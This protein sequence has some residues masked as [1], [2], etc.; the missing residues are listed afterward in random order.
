MILN[1]YKNDIIENKIKCFGTKRTIIKKIRLIKS[2]IAVFKSDIKKV[3]R[4][5]I[6]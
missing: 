3:C 4:L 1:E 6:S 2:T 5:V